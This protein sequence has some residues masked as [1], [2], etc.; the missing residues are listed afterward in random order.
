MYS[1]IER[2]DS[3]MALVTS[4][5]G[6]IPYTRFAYNGVNLM[7]VFAANSILA[8][9]VGPEA[10]II[11]MTVPFRNPVFT[12]WIYIIIVVSILAF[13]FMLAFAPL[14][15]YTAV[16]LAKDKE[17]GLERVMQENGLSRWIHFLSWLIFYT[18]VN[19]VLSLLYAILMVDSV[20]LHC[21][22]MLV[23][24][25]VFLALE[26]LFSFVWALQPLANTPKMA[27]FVTAFFFFASFVFSSAFD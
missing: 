15:F 2:L 13:F 20:Y 6:L 8:R 11:M 21:S 22:F 10:E 14:V 26:S 4:S 25:M 23:F 27:V 5:A 3:E 12:T 19:L 16:A 17:S 1:T 18:G 7:Q 24:M 9:Q